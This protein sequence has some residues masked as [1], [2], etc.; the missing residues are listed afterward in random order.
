MRLFVFAV[1]T[2]PLPSLCVGWTHVRLP[3]RALPPTHTNRKATLDATRSRPRIARTKSSVL[4]S[5]GPV[6]VPIG[7][8]AETAVANHSGY[9][10]ALLIDRISFTAGTLRAY[11]TP[12]DEA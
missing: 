3:A 2:W 7:H 10:A 9:D 4:A 12:P 6:L 8:V 1:P 11:S 5:A